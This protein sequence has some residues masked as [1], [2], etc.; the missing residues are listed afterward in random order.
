[1]PNRPFFKQYS[2][3]H[4]ILFLFIC[5]LIPSGVLLAQSDRPPTQP[6]PTRETPVPVEPGEK[7]VTGHVYLVRYDAVAAA[8]VDQVERQPVSGAAVLA[9]RHDRREVVEAKTDADGQYRL[10]LAPG[11]W[12]IV[13]KATDES[14]PD[15]WLYIDEA[16]EVTFRHSDV[17]E[18]QEIDFIVVPSE[19]GISGLIILPDGTAPDF[20]VGISLR[21]GEGVGREYKT[22]PGDG[23]FQIDLPPGRYEMLIHPDSDRFAGP[24]IEPINLYPGEQLDLG[25][26]ML[27]TRSATI[28]GQIFDEDGNGVAG[29]PITAWLRGGTAVVHTRSNE[30]GAY[31]LNLVPGGWHIQPSPGPDIPFLYTGKGESIELATGEVVEGVDFRVIAA[32]GIIE[33]GL[34]DEDGEIVTDIEGWVHAVDPENP[35]IVNGAPIREGRFELKLPPGKYQLSVHLPPGSPYAVNERF[36]VEVET[37]ETVTIRIP[38]ESRGAAITG[39]L[40]DPR[41]DTR[42]VTGV[43]GEVGAWSGDRYAIT[44]IDP[45]TGRYDLGVAA[46]VWHLDY[47]I[48]EETFV[49]IGGPQNIPVEAD[50]SVE[51]PLPVTARDGGISGTVYDPDGNP[52]PGAVVIFDG[53]SGDVKNLW[54]HTRT[55]ENGN[56]R[57]SL[58]HGRYLVGSF[59]LEEDWIYPVELTVGVEPNGVVEGVELHFHRPDAN[60]FGRVTVPHTNEI[61][62]VLLSGWTDRGGFSWSTTLLELAD[63]QS[64]I[65]DYSLPVVSGAVWQVQAIFETETDY[66]IGYGRAK[67][68]NERVELDITLE[69]PQ[70]KPAPIVVT[71]DAAEAQRLTLA[72]GTVLFVPAGAMPVDG[73][74]TLR[75]DPIAKLPHQRHA[76]IIKYGYAIHASD[77]SGR[78]IEEGFLHHVLIEFPF[79]HDRV[80]GDV[81]QIKPAYFSTTTNSWTLPERYVVDLEAGVVKMAID[82]FTDFA[83]LQ[84][85][86]D[87][88]TQSEAAIYLPLLWR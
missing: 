37:G 19:S 7:V 46:G 55:D 68:E 16:V 71:F 6:E 17:D 29:M 41:S 88:P 63:D 8:E 65:A 18:K 62:T 54:L 39:H 11:S 25:E 13:V 48:D 56:F 76:R 58:P 26:I 57:Y 49:K 35:D 38:V 79:E 1:M 27:L 85:E 80:E 10:E 42:S 14:R 60:L 82:H 87:P 44:H 77:E 53:L 52:L 40:T 21:N 59:T 81:D 12:S 61:G 32:S 51:L 23:S 28:S 3:T 22:E 5:M 83:L 34:V 67:V 20:A 30:A 15:G 45:E 50:Q 64:A 72:D 36:E 75:I 24:K 78:P 73:N 2:L 43:R 66:W 31:T 86:V 69:G 70:P 33:G 47:K 9:Q 74:V 84:P 4:L